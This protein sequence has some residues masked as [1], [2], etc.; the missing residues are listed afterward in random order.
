VEETAQSAG[1]WRS[2]KF[3]GVLGSG[4]SI[5][6]HLGLLVAAM[7]AQPAVG[8]TEMV[9]DTAPQA[10]SVQAMFAEVAE[11]ETEDKAVFDVGDGHEG[12][13]DGHGLVD[14]DGDDRKAGR[15]D[16]D[17]VES[18][19]S[20]EGPSDNLDAGAAER[21]WRRSSCCFSIGP[22]EDP[23]GTPNGLA[24]DQD[25]LGSEATDA[26]GDMRGSAPADAAGNAGLA[27]AGSG[28]GSRT[29]ACTSPRGGSTAGNYRIRY[30]RPAGSAGA[31]NKD[32]PDANKAAAGAANNGA[33]GAKKPWS[34]A[35]A[36]RMAPAAP[37]YPRVMEC[38]PQGAR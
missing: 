26:G 19:A 7:V 34:G 2:S 32:A 22:F 29:M 31:A 30:S 11:R 38:D 4:T 10:Y 17:A 5:G 24:W 37:V 27:P 28:T 25:R 15:A 3:R 36:K 1:G 12:A 6:L 18:R 13:A 8:P 16:A 20:F 9:D 35:V 23:S 33:P 21:G 14:T